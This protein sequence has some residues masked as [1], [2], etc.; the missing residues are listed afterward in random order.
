M[1]MRSN[2]PGLT[3]PRRYAQRMRMNSPDQLAYVL[4][5]EARR[6][7]GAASALLSN[8]RGALGVTLKYGW[9]PSSTEPRSITKFAQDHGFEYLS[10]TTRNG[11]QFC[12]FWMVSTS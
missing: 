1:S 7:G 4:R 5:G 12:N 9:G 10:L 2:S 6:M 11:Q 3:P 8:V